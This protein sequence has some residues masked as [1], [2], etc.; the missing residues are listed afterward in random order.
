MKKNKLNPERLCCCHLYKHEVS[1]GQ[2][3]LLIPFTFQVLF[4]RLQVLNKRDVVIAFRR[5]LFQLCNYY[6]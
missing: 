3:N 6:E 4:S 1:K 5:L 2:V